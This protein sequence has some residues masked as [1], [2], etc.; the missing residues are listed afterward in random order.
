MNW[1]AAEEHLQAVEKAYT[2]IGDPGLFV[3]NYV[4]PSLKKRLIEGERTVDLYDEIMGV[5]L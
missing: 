1:A 5:K 3:L 4:L 2:E